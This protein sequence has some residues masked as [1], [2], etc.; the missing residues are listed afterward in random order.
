MLAEIIEIV[1]ASRRIRISTAA[2]IERG[3]EYASLQ[4]GARVL[5]DLGRQTKETVDVHVALSALPLKVV[6]K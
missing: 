6:L 4:R 3:K 5:V 2:S 1:R